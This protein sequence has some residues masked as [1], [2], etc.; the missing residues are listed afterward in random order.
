MVFL[1]ILGMPRSCGS[2]GDAPAAEEDKHDEAGAG[3][4]DEDDA[5]QKI[6]EEATAAWAAE[7]EQFYL[8]AQA[9]DHQRLN[10][11]H[12]Q[13]YAKRAEFGSEPAWSAEQEASVNE[14]QAQIDA[15]QK[16]PEP[17]APPANIK[18]H[19]AG[20]GKGN[21]SGVAGNICKDKQGPIVA[22]AKAKVAAVKGKGKGNTVDDDE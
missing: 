15:P 19:K 3:D 9:A 8:K 22:A 13:M 5:F 16:A 10:E 17:V 4:D 11:L 21:G 18:L 1:L 2:R 6:V 14:L 12:K 7:R 20:G